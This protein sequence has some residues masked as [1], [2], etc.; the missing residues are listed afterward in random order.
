MITD[1]EHAGSRSYNDEEKPME[2]KGDTGENKPERSGPVIAEQGPRVP[3]Q[4]SDGNTVLKDNGYEKESKAY[5]FII[6]G[7]VIIAAVAAF[8]IIKRKANKR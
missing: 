7:L 4:V 2:K 6:I 5:V 8:F 1:P 3:D